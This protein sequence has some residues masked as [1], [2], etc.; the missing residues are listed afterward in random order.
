[1]YAFS[2]STGNQPIPRKAYE[3]SVWTGEFQ[4]G[5]PS[6]PR[7]PEVF[8]SVELEP[9]KGVGKEFSRIVGVTGSFTADTG[10]E[11][12]RKFA[13]PNLGSKP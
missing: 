11:P 2:F 1:M 5:R 6:W 7:C 3:L 8:L 10:A 4:G 13:E 12:L 9:Q